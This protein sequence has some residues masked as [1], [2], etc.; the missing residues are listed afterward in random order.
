MEFRHYQSGAVDCIKPFFNGI[1]VL[2]TG[3]GKSVV[4]A[5]IAK[6]FHEP[7]LILQPSKEILEQNYQKIL[8][9]IDDQNEVGIYSALM[10]QKDIKRIT[11][12]TIGSIKDYE[13]FRHFKIIIQ[14]ECHLTNAKGG[15]YEKL[16]R[17]NQPRILVGLTATPYRLHT[18]ENG[19]CWRFLHRTRPK[20]FKDIE[21]VYQNKTAFDEGFLL[22]PEYYEFD[23]DTSVL[24]TKG[25]EYSEESILKLNKAMGLHDKITTIV[26]Q[27]QRKHILI[28]TTSIEEAEI[29]ADKLKSAGISSRE[30]S[31]L[32]TKKERE[33]ILRDFKSGAIRAVVNVGV[34]TTGFDFPSLDCVIGAR[35]TMSLALYY[36]MMG[37]GVRI[38]DGKTSW[39]YFD[40]CGNVKTFGKVESYVIDGKGSE[41]S[42]KNSDGFLIRS[43]SANKALEELPGGE[44]VLPFGKFKDHKIKDVDSNYLKYCLDN[45]EDFYYASKFS[46]ELKRRASV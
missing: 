42:I 23:Y 9:F 1:L 26:E 25:S 34:L 38:C 45:F 44:W 8:A 35:P 3:S 12:A 14:D 36:Q 18:S 29:I 13:A 41:T 32:N 15:Q 33:Q 2:P 20:I 4:I 22:K 5:G 17:Y 43:A 27:C 31:S 10:G 24:K 37:R 30:I 21:F 40:L 28:F 19:Y 16:F 46:E 6:K 11:L 7:I 39:D